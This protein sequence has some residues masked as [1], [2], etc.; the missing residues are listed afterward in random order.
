MNDELM[1]DYL[2]QM[3]QYRP[4][5]EQLRR[6]QAYV[7]ALRQQ[8]M[9]SPQ[10]GMAG[11]VYVAPSIT[12][13]LAQLGQSYMGR[14]GQEDLDT[15]YSDLNVRRAAALRRMQDQRKLDKTLSAAP[16]NMY[17][18]NDEE[19]FRGYTLPPF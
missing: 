18:P 12:Q 19:L 13:G 6:R 11:R 17:N 4:E 16:T 1:F 9:E 14:K 15:K 8:G 10:G 3:G 2:L 7:N 5:E